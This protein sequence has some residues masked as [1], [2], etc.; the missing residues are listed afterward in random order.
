MLRARFSKDVETGKW[1][2]LIT[3]DTKTAYR[4]YSTSISTKEELNSIIQFG[5]RSLNIRTGPLLSVD[6]MIMKNNTQYVFFVAHH[7]IVDLVSWRLILGDLEEYLVT[8]TITGY[9]SLSFQSWCNLQTKYDESIV[10]NACMV[11]FSIDK[12]TTS[13]IIGS[14]NRTFGTQTVELLQAALL[15]S[16][17]RTFND[18]EAPVIHKEGYS[19]EPWDPSINITQTIGWFTTVSPIYAPITK[20][21]DIVNIVRRIKDISRSTTSITKEILFNFHSLS[22]SMEQQ[23]GLFSPVEHTTD[24]LH[25][26]PESTVMPAIFE[27]DASLENKE[28]QISIMLNKDLSLQPRIR[29]WFLELQESITE[30]AQRLVEQSPGF[31]PGDFSLLCNTLSLNAFNALLQDILPSLG[32]SNIEDIQDIY[33]C[34]SLQQM[35]WLSGSRENGYYQPYVL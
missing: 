24:P 27:I 8:G 29:A 30:A 3:G 11:E 7:L 10:Q 16:F 13:C 23:D 35:I 6:L 17:T 22:L 26:M 14:A 12:S 20:D 28:L 5:Q 19:H 2:Q 33:P 1:S 32:I 31:T 21:I 9:K 25:E 34:T 15:H 4:L 18:Q